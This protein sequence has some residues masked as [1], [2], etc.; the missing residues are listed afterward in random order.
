MNHSVQKKRVTHLEGDMVVTQPDF[1]LL[2]TDDILLWPI[3]VVFP[4][5]V[6]SMDQKAATPHE[7]L[8]LTS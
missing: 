7:L 2:L 4:T 1:E 6:K 8:E 5:R 3:C